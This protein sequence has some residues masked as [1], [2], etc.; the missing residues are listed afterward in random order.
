MQYDGSIY[1]WIK[2][3]DFWRTHKKKTVDLFHNVHFEKK[4]RFVNVT[5]TRTSTSTP[6][7]HENI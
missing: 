5:R 2:R 4:K 1:I 6:L 3:K 7:S